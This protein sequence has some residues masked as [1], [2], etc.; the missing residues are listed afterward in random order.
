M[1]MPFRRICQ[2]LAD[3]RGAPG[4]RAT[5]PQWGPKFFHV[6]AVFGKKIEK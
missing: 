6:H 2:P 3:P 5:S 4:M 1:L